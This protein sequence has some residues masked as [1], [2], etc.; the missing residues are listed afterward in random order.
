MS[1]IF[2]LIQS[3]KSF[4]GLS[5]PSWEAGY[6]EGFLYI[7]IYLC[8]CVEQIVK[9]HNFSKLYFVVKHM[10]SKELCIPSGSEGNKSTEIKLQN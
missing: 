8:V 7:F 2:S 10:S 6:L 9:Q 1:S 3:W 5:N 4:L